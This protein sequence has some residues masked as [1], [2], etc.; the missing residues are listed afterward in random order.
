MT[1]TS[2]T[3]GTSFFPSSSNHALIWK[4]KMST[5]VLGSDSCPGT[6]RC[7]ESPC[8]AW[9]AAR[10]WIWGRTGGNEASRKLEPPEPSWCEPCPA[11]P[12]TFCTE[13]TVGEMQLNSICNVWKVRW[14]RCL[15]HKLRMTQFRTYSDTFTFYTLLC[16]RFD[17][18]WMILPFLQQSTQNNP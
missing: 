14:T 3:A 9:R 7:R 15:C 18:I 2:P 4:V 12:Q 17:C 8:P 5:A 6:W 13:Q 1:T 10:L 11:A 16:L